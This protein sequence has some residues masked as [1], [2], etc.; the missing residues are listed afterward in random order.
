M[1]TPEFWS[2]TGPRGRM[3]ATLLSPLGA[4]YGLSVCARRASSHPYRAKARVVCVGNL[5]A[6]GTGKNSIVTFLSNGNGT[7][8]EVDQWI[9]A[10]QFN[11]GP[12]STAD[13]NGDGKA[14][15]V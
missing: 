7:Y 12:W 3:L 15:L 6:G 1:R 13:V 2:D 14:D 5:T 11:I 8:T 9:R 4:L 10:G